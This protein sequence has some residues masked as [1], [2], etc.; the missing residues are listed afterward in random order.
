MP[1]RSRSWR[2]RR[3]VARASILVADAKRP[4]GLGLSGVPN[5]VPGDVNTGHAGAA[6]R[7]QTGIVSLPAAD[8]EARETINA[9]EHLEERRGIQ[10]LTVVVVAR[11]HQFC[12]HLGVLVPV[13]AY[14]LVIHA[15]FPSGDRG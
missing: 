13:A 3:A 12:P 15:S 11:P 14:F 6:L 10:A 5:E 4:G 2:F 8:V 9:G 1:L 7:E